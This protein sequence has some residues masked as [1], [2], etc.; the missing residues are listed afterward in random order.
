MK[1]RPPGSRRGRTLT[2]ELPEALKAGIEAAAEAQGLTVAEWT[3]R[4]LA[5]AVNPEASPP[6][7]LQLQ[8]LAERL[9]GITRRLEALEPRKR[10]G[11]V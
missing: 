7:P 10:R 6:G 5:A 8:A 9:E 1:P 2:V 11:M 4:T 3:R